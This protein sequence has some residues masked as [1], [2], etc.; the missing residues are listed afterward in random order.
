MPPRIALDQLAEE[1]SLVDAVGLAYPAPLA[2]IA[3]ALMRGLPYLVEC[4][5]ELVPFLCHNLR[6][7]LHS[8]GFRGAYVDGRPAPPGRG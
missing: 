4:A 2:D 7:R 5:K 6:Q 3:S 8:H 1:I